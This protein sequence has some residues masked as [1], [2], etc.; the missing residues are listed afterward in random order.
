MDGRVAGLGGKEGFVQ[1]AGQYGEKIL[2]LDASAIEAQRA[3]GFESLLPAADGLE[4]GARKRRSTCKVDGIEQLRN[5]FG[6]VE[7][8]LRAAREFSQA[9]L[10]FD[11]ACDPSS[12]QQFVWRLGD[13]GIEGP[14]GLLLAVAA[15]IAHMRLQGRGLLRVGGVAG[16]E[17]P[18][19]F[20]FGNRA[21]EP[22]EQQVS[23]V[24]Q[25][26]LAERDSKGELEERGTGG[27]RVAEEGS[28]DLAAEA[29]CGRVLG[30]DEETSVRMGG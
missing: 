11:H 10:G 16:G 9:A 29:A 23:G 22:A 4:F 2:P 14:V 12:G 7:R 1:G 19:E 6:P 27:A 28:F 21:G 18:V 30:D 5:Q 13:E 25:G 15:E 26:N 20:V 24:W 3:A 8:S 17:E